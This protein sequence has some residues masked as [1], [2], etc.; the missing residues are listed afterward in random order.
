M[1]P[2]TDELP[3][4]PEP[5]SAGRPLSGCTLTL[6]EFEMRTELALKCDTCRFPN[7]ITALHGKI[8][9]IYGI[10]PSRRVCCPGCRIRNPCDD[11]CHVLASTGR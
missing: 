5:F 1:L 7:V 9:A 6:S 2:E 8:L 4:R 11:E 10:F 3:R